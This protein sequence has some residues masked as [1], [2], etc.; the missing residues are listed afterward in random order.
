MS[1]SVLQIIDRVIVLGFEKQAYLSISNRVYPRN[2][3]LSNQSISANIF[4]QF[5]KLVMS[6]LSRPQPNARFK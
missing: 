4:N 6:M 5:F 1:V 2:K 3:T